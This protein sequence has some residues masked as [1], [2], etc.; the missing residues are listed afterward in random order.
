MVRTTGRLVFGGSGPATEQ[1][2]DDDKLQQLTKE[3]GNR[4]KAVAEL[5]STEKTFVSEMTAAVL[6]LQQGLVPFAAA[7][8]RFHLLVEV[9][10]EPLRRYGAELAAEAEAAAE[11]RADAGKARL[12]VTPEDLTVI[13][14]NVEQLL[15]FNRSFLADLEAAMAAGGQGAVVEVFLK[16]A[17][18]MRMFSVYVNN[19]DRAR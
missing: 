10:L 19:F 8:T 12:A 14:S 2:D 15:G 18:F 1:Q 9:F 3:E 5:L 4:S 13:F 17:P 6:V 11:D 16:A 7:H